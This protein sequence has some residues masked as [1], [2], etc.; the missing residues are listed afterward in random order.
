[1]PIEKFLGVT[2]ETLP[3]LGVVPVRLGIIQSLRNDGAFL[4]F[5]RPD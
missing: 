5:L 3:H 1:M 2:E 4:A